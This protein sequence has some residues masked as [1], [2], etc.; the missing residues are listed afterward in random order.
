MTAAAEH[1]CDGVEIDLRVS[2][3]GQPFL[4]H[5][6]TMRRTVGLR[7]PVE[8]TPSFILRKLMVKENGQPIPTLGLALTALPQNLFLAVDVKTPWA[9]RPLLREVRAQRLESRVRIWCTSARAL[10]WVTRRAPDVEC[11]YLKTALSP[12]AKRNF[13]KKAVRLGA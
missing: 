2:V 8:L 7:W 13:I 11:A 12:R 10:G 9:V 1:G 5:D 3:S 4:M 6:N